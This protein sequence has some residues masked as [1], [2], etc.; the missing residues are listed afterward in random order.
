MPALFL[1]KKEGKKYECTICGKEVTKLP[2]H[3]RKHT[4]AKPYKCDVCGKAFSKSSNR[5]VHMRTHTG[6]KPYKC[7]VSGCGKAFSQR[8]N[9]KRHAQ[10]CRA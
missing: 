4:G 9:L 3:G 8:S 2:T 6:T 7:A 10:L 5:A 1:V